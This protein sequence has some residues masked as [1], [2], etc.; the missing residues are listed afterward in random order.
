MSD[1]E[2]ERENSI[3][4]GS[5][6]ILSGLKPVE[7]P[8]PIKMITDLTDEEKKQIIADIKAGKE[9]EHYKLK[10]FKNGT[11]R[12]VKKKAKTFVEKVITKNKANEKLDTDKV[13]LTN[14]QLINQRIIELEVKYAKFESKYKKQKKR[15]NDILKI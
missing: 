4:G 1:I 10:E 2:V 5:I 11:S 3:K 7:E 8:T 12:I 14:D 13:F 15:V 9:N 6:N